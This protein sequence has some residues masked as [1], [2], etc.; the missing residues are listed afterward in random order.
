MI[1]QQSG[2]ALGSNID[3]RIEANNPDQANK[4][5]KSL[6]DKIFS[7]EAKFSRFKVESELSKF[8]ARAGKEVEISEDFAKFLEKV[9]QM[10]RLTDGLFNPF[11]LPALQRAGYT[12]SLIDDNLSGTDYSQR[13]IANWS[14]LELGVGRAKI[15]RG[16]AID[17]GGIGKGYLADSLAGWLDESGTEVYCLSLG[18]D[19]IA[20]GGTWPIYIQ[21]AKK[22]AED[23]AVYETDRS[24]F[25]VATSGQTRQQNGRLQ[26]H[27]I[28]VSTGE[29]SLSEFE[30]A[31]VVSETATIADVLASLALM[32]GRDFARRFVES[33][34]L[35]AIL[36]QSSDKVYVDGEGIQLLGNKDLAADRKR[37]VLN[38]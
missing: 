14:A 7:F 25:A 12:R 22:R 1:F 28:D 38:A 8:N 9:K 5:F 20:R 18:G 10:S 21:S 30:I 35:Q 33:G 31:T 24:R 19:I 3:L 34:H 29:L 37:R 36:L 23:V 6:W 2:Q 27:Q 13:M 17:I 11:V 15:P 26:S 4:V 16:T 32:R